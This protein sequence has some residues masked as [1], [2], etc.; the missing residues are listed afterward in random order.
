M[1]D[2]GVRPLPYGRGSDRQSRSAHDAI[3][4]ATVREWLLEAHSYGR[5]SDRKSRSAHDAIR[6]ATVREWLLEAHP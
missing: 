2:R 1:T 3:R 5:G 4:A 6:A